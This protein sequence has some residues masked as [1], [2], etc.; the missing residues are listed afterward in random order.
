MKLFLYLMIVVLVFDFLALL[1]LI[2]SGANGDLIAGAVLEFG[3]HI[4]AMTV[5]DALND[6]LQN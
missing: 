5:V 4:Y 6:K 3:I 1:V 2:L